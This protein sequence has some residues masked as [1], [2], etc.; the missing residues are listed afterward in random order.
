MSLNSTAVLM[1]D[2]QNMY[3]S[4][5][6][7]RDALGWP[8]IWRLHEVVAECAALLAEA[9]AH[10]V[11]VIYSRAMP[12]TAGA[13]GAHP[14]FAALAAT[15]GDRLPTLTQDQTRF[16]Q[17]IMDAVAP[18]PGDLVLDKSR[19]SFFEYTELE[20]VLHNLGITR[21]LVAGLQT[22]V[23]V[24]ATVR[25]GLAHNF[26]MAVAEDAVSTDGPA[27]HWG[28]LNSMRVLYTEVAPWRELLASDAAWN[29][30]FTTPNYGRDPEYWDARHPVS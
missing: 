30:A 1:I 12:S 27:L 4:E 7:M 3:I 11:P 26:E 23:C 10:G 21:L 29:T 25:S 24:E 14:R 15:L 5:D 18:E 8:P 2:V 17:Q 19:S 22:N 9:R 6:G 28:A 13:V 20:P 16:S